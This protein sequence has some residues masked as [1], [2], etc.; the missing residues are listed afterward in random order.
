VRYRFVLAEKAHHSVRLLCKALNVSRSGFYAWC[1][2][3]ESRQAR[4]RGR[5][6][7]KIR[8]S[9]KASGGVYGSPRVLRDLRAEGEHVGRTRVANIM[10][11]A[12]L[13]GRHKR[14]FH[15]TT[16]SAHSQPVARNL[17]KR[18]FSPVARDTVWAVE[19]AAPQ[20]AKARVHRVLS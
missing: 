1:H 4:E 9:H 19:S 7:A 2:R 18:D 20:S 17:I 16:D 8:A 13:C 5:L 6:E 12:G 10:R 11:D 14:Q 3:P 15:K